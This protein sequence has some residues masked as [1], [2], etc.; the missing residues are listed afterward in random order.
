MNT[1]HSRRLFKV[2]RPDLTS[3]TCGPRNLFPK[4]VTVQ[5][6]KQALPSPGNFFCEA[7]WLK[8]RAILYQNNQK[9]VHRTGSF[10]E[11][12]SITTLKPVAEPTS[13]RTDKPMSIIKNLLASNRPNG[14]L[15]QFYC[16][17][18]GQIMTDITLARSCSHFQ[19]STIQI[20][21]QQLMLS[22]AFCRRRVSII[23]QVSNSFRVLL[24]RPS[25]LICEIPKIF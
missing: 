17:S 16:F 7:T 20:N 14:I 13:G 11:L 6:I 19:G 25:A 1:R 10:W 12:C 23:V 24:L 5:I 8:R 3:K 21:R 2:S 18:M 15:R 22:E 4:V 9:T